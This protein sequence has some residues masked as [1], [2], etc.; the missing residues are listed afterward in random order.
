MVGADACGRGARTGAE[1][2]GADR[3]AATLQTHHV[4][5]AWRSVLHVA[6]IQAIIQH[7][8]AT[9]AGQSVTKPPSSCLSTH[10]DHWYMQL[11]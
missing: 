8:M 6:Q 2:E 10:S 7:C 1:V 3:K 11:Y 4:W 5:A 9:P